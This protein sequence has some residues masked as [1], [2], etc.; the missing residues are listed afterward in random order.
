MLTASQPLASK[1]RSLRE[2]GA[3][4]DDF[5]RHKTGQILLPEYPRA[6]LNYR[7]TDVQAAIGIAQLSSKLDRIM[8]R[9]S[10]L[11]ARYTERL[12]KITWLRPTAVPQGY[13]HSYQSYVCLYQPI[14]PTAANAEALGRQRQALMQKLR[15][16]GIETR[17]G[18]HAIH[19]LAHYAKRYALTP[20]S[21]PNAWV[22]DQA[23][24]APPLYAQMTDD[25]QDRVIDA[26]ASLGS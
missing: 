9:R 16:Q 13:L 15:E 4:V 1:I 19:L 12:Q 25:E 2:H 10:Q 11:A 20:A 8:A 26:L 14:A 18:T 7:M 5:Q 17:Q 24:L 6:G 3:D 23:A 21:L 22:A